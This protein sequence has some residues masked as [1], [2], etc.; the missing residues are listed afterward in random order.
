MGYREFRKVEGAEV[1]GLEGPF[2]YIT[3]IILYYDPSEGKYYNAAQDM[4]VSDSEMEYH[5]GHRVKD[6]NPLTTN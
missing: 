1:S 3:G 2:R 5:H 6:W 4:Y